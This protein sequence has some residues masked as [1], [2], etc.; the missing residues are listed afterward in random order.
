[1]PDLLLTN[2]M[3]VTVA[4]RRLWQS[5][6]RVDLH[7]HGADVG[8]GDKAIDRRIVAALGLGDRSGWIYISLNRTDIGVG[9]LSV[10]NQITKRILIG[11]E[12]RSLR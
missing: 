3:S 11:A 6:G 10:S 9:H 4:L 12:M 1:M 5:S 2:E 8:I 7:L